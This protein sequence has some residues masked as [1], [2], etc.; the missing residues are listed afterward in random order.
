MQM[1]LFMYRLANSPKESTSNKYKVT[2]WDKGW[3]KECK[4]AI[5]F[6]LAN[7]V[8]TQKKAAYNASSFVTRAQMA[9]FMD[10][11]YDNVLI[12]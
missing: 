4:Q 3:N 12:K 2:D 8:S 1:A 11:L 9:A 7:G 5:N 10:R 6:L